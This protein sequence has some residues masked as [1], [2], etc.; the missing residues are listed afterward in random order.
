M[1]LPP[2]AAYVVRQGQ[3][4]KH[5]CHWPGCQEQV[6]PAKWGCRRHWFMLPRKFRDEIWD[7]YRIGQEI[8][9]TP[10]REYLEV[11]RKIQI[12]ISGQP[13]DKAAPK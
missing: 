3:S 12:W 5:E 8:D 7:T 10:S 4:R 6:P 13:P 1:T 9:G 2:K 11:A